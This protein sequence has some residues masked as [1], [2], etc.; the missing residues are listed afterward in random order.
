MIAPGTRVP[1]ATVAVGTAADADAPRRRGAD[2][3]LLATA[4]AL[5][6]IGLVAIYTASPSTTTRPAPFAADANATLSDAYF[7]QRHAIWLVLGILGA[8]VLYGVPARILQRVSVLGFMG[9]LAVLAAVAALGT[10]INGSSRWALSTGSIQPSELAK[11]VAVVYLADWLAGRGTELRQWSRG[12]LPYSL[13]IGTVCG[14]IILQGHFS[15]SLLIL[16]VAAAMLYVAEADVWQMVRAGLIAGLVLA[17]FV[18]TASYRMQRI[19]SFLDPAADPLGAGYQMHHVA[20]AMN[21]T[22]WFGTGLA[23]GH[24]K[25]A[26]PYGTAHTDTVF[27]VIAEETGVVG[28]LLVIA[29][30]GVLGWRGYRAA[31]GAADRF[32]RLVAVGVTT[33]LL[34]QAAIHIGVAAA[35]LPPTGVTLPFISYGGSSLVTCL[36]AMG[37]LLGVARRS[38]PERARAYGTVDLGWGNGRSRLSRAHRARRAGRA[39]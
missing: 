35:L 33:G 13:L 10:Q 1:A 27:A 15:T 19:Q 20:Q 26:F 34:A 6:L 23:Q 25:F 39:G 29:L 21:D 7:L 14:L 12:I 2:R 37:L 4:T 24:V 32:D 11:L 30:F 5:V 8:S 3:A 9:M 31:A 38:D 16:V 28:S 17:F 22:G 36:L 18:A